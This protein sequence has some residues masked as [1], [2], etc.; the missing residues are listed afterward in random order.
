MLVDIFICL[1]DFYLRNYWLIVNFYLKDDHLIL[2][3]DL[4]LILSY[5]LNLII[6]T[7]SVF[8]MIIMI[9]VI[10][11]MILMFLWFINNVRYLYDNLF[12]DFNMCLLIGWG[13]FNL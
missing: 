2:D 9:R 1:N 4:I 7:F 11:M 12:N 3:I 5:Y 6:D 8:I 13:L 10:H